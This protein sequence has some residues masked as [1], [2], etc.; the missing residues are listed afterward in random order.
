[1][2]LHTTFM[3]DLDWRAFAECSVDQHSAEYIE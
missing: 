2:Y 3:Q 1:M